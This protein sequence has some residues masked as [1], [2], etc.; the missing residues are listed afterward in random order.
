[1][2]PKKKSQLGREK[3]GNFYDAGPQGHIETDPFT[4][5]YR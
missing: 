5:V 1:M 2:K 3:C 4:V